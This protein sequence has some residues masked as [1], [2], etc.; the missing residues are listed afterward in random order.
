MIT[1]SVGF[2]TG[3]VAEFNEAFGIQLLKDISHD[4]EQLRGTTSGDGYFIT[5][6]GIAYVLRN[7]PEQGGAS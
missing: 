1:Y 2:K 3:H 6:E 4:P 5:H 7:D